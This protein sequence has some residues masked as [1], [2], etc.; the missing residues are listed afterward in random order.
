MLGIR[1][2]VWKDAP[3]RLESA[4]MATYTLGQFL[5]SEGALALAETPASS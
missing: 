1:K 5:L 2:F 4:V 3:D